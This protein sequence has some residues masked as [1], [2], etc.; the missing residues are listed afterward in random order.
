MADFVPKKVTDLQTP[1]LVIYKHIVQEN[2][3]RMIKRAKEFGVSLRPHIKTTKCIEAVLLQTGGKKKC[4]VAS[5]LPEVEMLC[6][7][8]FNDVLYGVPLCQSKVKR[9]VDIAEQ[10][11]DFSVMIDREEM[12]DVL[13]KH[14]IPRNKQWCVFVEVDCDN[15]RSGILHS[16]K[17]AISLAVKLAN[18]PA[19]K[20][21]GL[22]AHCGNSYCA[23]NLDHVYN[24]A[25]ST[26]NKLLEL[27]DKLK[28]LGIPCPTYGI[29][30]TPTCSNPHP[31]MGKLTE[32]HPG[33][34]ILYDV[35]QVGASINRK[36]VLKLAPP[37]PPTGGRTK[38][39]PSI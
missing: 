8:G 18:S 31:A 11:Q 19:I 3:Q 29:G 28:E 30:S 16:S 12:V 20:F 2:A 38:R 32:W 26:T 25:S 23:D 27:V 10:M 9:C 13:E 5:T 14:N 34:Y 6:S 15:R 17:A 37:N 21:R 7:N 36:S 4:V 35:M 39:G 22:Y 33:N 1:T 24:V